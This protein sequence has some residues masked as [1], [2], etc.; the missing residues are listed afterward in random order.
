LLLLLRYRRGIVFYGGVTALLLFGFVVILKAEEIAEGITFLTQPV[1][2]EVGKALMAAGILAGSVDIY[3]KRRLATDFVRDIS[4]FIEGMGL[5][6]EFQDEIAFIRR[7]P[8]YRKDFQLEYKIFDDPVLIP[9]YVRVRTSI[10]YELI[11][12]T[13]QAQPYEHV[14][15]VGNSYAH[16][17]ASISSDPGTTY[18]ISSARTSY[19][20]V[21][22]ARIQ[23]CNSDFRSETGAPGP[24]SSGPSPKSNQLRLSLFLR[25]NWIR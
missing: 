13:E 19:L 3:L 1:I 16:V 20:A 12:P 15:A 18:S 8:L 4:P 10:W 14:V 2:E 21:T 17:A 23:V 9:G 25:P 6:Q 24:M 5:P 22:S 7:I 11:N